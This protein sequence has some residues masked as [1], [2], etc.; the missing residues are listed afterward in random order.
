MQYD[1][2]F[3]KPIAIINSR[4]LVFTEDDTITYERKRKELTDAN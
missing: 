1:N 2:E 3:L 4:V